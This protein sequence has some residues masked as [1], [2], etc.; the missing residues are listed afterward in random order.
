M[1]ASDLPAKN[2]VPF[3]NGADATHKRV[4]PTPSQTAT[5][6]DAPASFTTGFPPL[7]FLNKAAG[8]IPPNG[9][10]ENGIHNFTTAWTRWLA[11]GG[12]IV[13][14]DASFSSSVGGY[15]KGAIVASSTFGKFWLSTVDGNLTNPDGGGA[16][17]RQFSTSGGLINVQIFSGSA[18]YTPTLGTQS[19]I[20]DL[21]GSGGGGG[22]SPAMNASQFAAAGGGGQGGRAVS[23]L[24]SGFSGISIGIG[25]G[26][27]GGIGANNGTAGSVTSF[28]S[29]LSATGGFGGSYANAATA[30]STQLGG[31]G[32]SATG[33]N[34]SNEGGTPGLPAISFA[35]SNLVS[36]SGGGPGGGPSIAGSGNGQNG[37]APGAGGSGAVGQNSAVAAAGGQ[38]S[39]GI[40][41]IYEYA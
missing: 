1:Q 40:V 13:P 11:A 21:R 41:I 3:A 35:S 29:I 5:A 22:G 37:N 14:F 24:I 34:I 9:A 23:R 38:G 15:P 36:G 4:I 6:T 12:S 30:G 31:V 8:G 39:N 25:P 20:V 26:G 33:G 32:G 19:V 2:T 16:G 27:S 17:W 7:T 10:D 28:G 18:T